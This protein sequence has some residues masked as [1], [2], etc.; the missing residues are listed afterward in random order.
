MERQPARRDHDGAGGPTEHNLRAVQDGA[1]RVGVRAGERDRVA[2]GSRRVIRRRHDQ[3]HAAGSVVGDHGTDGRL[4]SGRAERVG[5]EVQ[6]EVTP[7]VRGTGRKRAPGDRG[8]SVVVPGGEEDAPAR[9]SERESAEAERRVGRVVH[10]QRVHRGVAGQRGTRRQPDVL[11]GVRARREGRGVV[12]GEARGVERAD[13]QAGHVTGPIP[14]GDRPGSDQ[15]VG[16]RRGRRDRRSRR[17]ADQAERAGRHAEENR[18]GRSGGPVEAREGQLGAIHA[19]AAD[20]VADHA[21]AR[22][23]RD[24]ADGLRRHAVDPAQEVETAAAE[25]DRRGVGQ[26]VRQVQRAA[27]AERQAAV[28]EQDR[29]RSGQLTGVDELHIAAGDDGGPGGGA[30][31]VEVAG[32]VVRGHRLD[33]GDGAGE[34]AAKVVGVVDVA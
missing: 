19:G 22:R 31:R 5:Q 32:V 11:R 34:L 12:A 28:V 6:I 20:R 25:R 10:G 1:A 24:G 13:A 26:S 27:I 29:R 8:R 3:P 23:G 4:A 9:G 15:V 7:D 18:R 33:V 30:V 16:E 21:D 2:Q 17:A 14:R